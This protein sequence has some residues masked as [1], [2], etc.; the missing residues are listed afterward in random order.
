MGI[1]HAGFTADQTVQAVANHFTSRGM[2]VRE[3]FSSLD[4]DRNGMISFDEFVQGI[5]ACLDY[6]GQAKTSRD[7]LWLIYRRFDK[8]GD[9]RLDVEEFAKAYTTPTAHTTY[10]YADRSIGVAVGTVVS[11]PSADSVVNRIAMSLQRQ[12]IDAAELFETLDKNRD[13]TLS[14]AELDKLVLSLEPNLSLTDREAVFAKFDKDRSGMVDVRE[15]VNQVQRSPAPALNLVEDKLRTLGAKLRDT[16]YT[17]A[18]ALS[19][20]DRYGTHQIMREDWLHAM[21]VLAPD[22]SLVDVDTVFRTFD[23]NGDGCMKLSE[24]RHFFDA[25]MTRR[26]IADRSV[27]PLTVA[28]PLLPAPVIAEQPWETAYLDQLRDILS[29]RR[30]GMPITEVFN[31]LDINASG[32]M[33]PSE[34]NRM[35]L[36][37]WKDLTVPQLDSLFSK[38][39]TS[40]SGVISVGEFV[41]RLG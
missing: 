39:N 14:R 30:T 15:F 18:H 19:L 4:K 11:G 25:A 29:Y 12:R 2:S 9:G 8:T 6:D 23:V 40:R 24:F 28:P 21:R 17:W 34:F 27:A 13:G 33:S 41:R 1:V 37:Y 3:A 35:V 32:T 5:Y 36:T 22:M 26:E 7:D 10:G 20:F 16:G 38:V 31:R